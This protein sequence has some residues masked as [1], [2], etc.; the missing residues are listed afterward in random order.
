VESKHVFSP[1]WPI[2]LRT[3][4]LSET[5][6]T[7][8]GAKFAIIAHRMAILLNISLLIVGAMATLAAFGG[9]TWR[10]GEEPILK[11][12]TVRGWISLFCLVLALSLG[13]VKELHAKYQDSRKQKDA[14]DRERALQAKLEGERDRLR[15]LGYSGLPISG[16]SVFAY[17]PDSGDI[18]FSADAQTIAHLKDDVKHACETPFSAYFG[19][20]PN[21]P[22]VPETNMACATAK[23]HLGQELYGTSLAKTLG[24]HASIQI[25]L[26]NIQLEGRSGSCVSPC[27]DFSIRYPQPG[28]G[29]A[30][31]P[32]PAD[33][34]I[35][36][37]EPTAVK[38][39]GFYVAGLNY[40]KK[41]R[42]AGGDTDLM[43]FK[44]RFCDDRPKLYKVWKLQL[45]NW[46][47]NIFFK[48]Y[49]LM[50]SKDYRDDS[51]VVAEYAY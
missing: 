38:G 23:W 36:D 6:G 16:F 43:T 4:N 3:C 49:D 40:E 9:E 37:N 25:G 22:G 7:L 18:P 33:F 26:R 42:F 29:V 30:N 21:Y 41:D 11:R 13:I 20:D 27:V 47:N 17:A 46:G 10:R 39:V 51:C 19:A 14:E 34:G 31:L 28:V 5:G 15:D 2:R 48:D 32:S 35:L 1:E 12:I 44:I 8:L 45:A 24:E 50:L